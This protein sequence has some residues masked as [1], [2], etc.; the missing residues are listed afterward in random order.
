MCYQ[1]LACLV[2]SVGHAAD[3]QVGNGRLFSFPK[4]KPLILWFKAGTSIIFQIPLAEQS[5]LGGGLV[6]H[7]DDADY[8]STGYGNGDAA[9]TQIL[10][11]HGARTEES[12]FD[13][14]ILAVTQ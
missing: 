4:K 6:K 11:L 2:A 1:I 13:G 8:A 14:R 7:C 5:D 9:G 3:H 12:E 10:M